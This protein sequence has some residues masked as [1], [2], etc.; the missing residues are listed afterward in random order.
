M[1]PFQLAVM[2]ATRRRSDVTE[3]SDEEGNFCG[4]KMSPPI[5]EAK[6]ENLIIHC[7]M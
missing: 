4:W 6:S 5:Q 3:D 2:Q 7:T 1:K